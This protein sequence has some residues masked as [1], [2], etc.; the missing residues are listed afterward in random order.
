M[1]ISAKEKKVKQERVSQNDDR[2]SGRNFRMAKK[3][4]P[5]KIRRELHKLLKER[6]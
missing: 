2:D 3:E 5:Y 6:K 4:K 1:D